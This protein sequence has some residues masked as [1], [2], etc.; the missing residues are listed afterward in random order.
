MLRLAAT[1]GRRGA[2]LFGFRRGKEEGSLG[3]EMARDRVE[4]RGG[5]FGSGRVGWMDWIGDLEEGG[6]QVEL[7]AAERRMD[8]TAP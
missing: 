8:W 2:P 1:E 7:V 4:A 3:Q 5:G 6:D